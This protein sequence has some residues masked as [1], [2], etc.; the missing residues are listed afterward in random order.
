MDLG[1]TLK[2]GGTAEAAMSEGGMETAV[3]ATMVAGGREAALLD[4]GSVAGL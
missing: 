2:L 1:V 4:T 3:G